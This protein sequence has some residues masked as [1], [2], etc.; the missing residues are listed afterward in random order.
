MFSTG[1][2]LISYIG[3]P[4]VEISLGIQD[5]LDSCSSQDTVAVIFR[6]SCEQTH[7]NRGEC[8][9]RSDA[10]SIDV[11]SYSRLPDVVEVL[12]L[13]ENV[14]TETGELR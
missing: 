1:I 11:S 14:H 8:R 2:S 12:S 6:F 3:R 13:P 9:E 5:L 7:W 4:Q 10:V